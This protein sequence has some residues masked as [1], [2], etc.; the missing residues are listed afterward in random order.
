MLPI[1]A[2]QTQDKYLVAKEPRSV[3]SSRSGSEPT[4][5]I[6]AVNLGELPFSRCVLNVP[7]PWRG[8]NRISIEHV[9]STTLLQAITRARNLGPEDSP[10]RASS[11]CCTG[12]AALTYNKAN[13]LPRFAAQLSQSVM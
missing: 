1:Y 4:K 9:A 5:S 12:R 7:H 8:G 3:A 2:T 6:D 11:G 13:E 10:G